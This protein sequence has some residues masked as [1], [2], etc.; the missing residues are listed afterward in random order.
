MLSRTSEVRSDSAAWVAICRSQAVIEFDTG[1]HILWA[2][3]IFL[4]LMGYC[5]AN[6]T[7]QH[8]RIFCAPELAETP[9]YQDFWRKLGAGEYCSGEFTRQTRTGA[10]VYL[11]ATYNPILGD[12]GRPLRILKIASDVTEH[13]RRSA[14]F[15][16]ISTA[17]VRSQAVIE[18]ALDGT[19]LTAND[20]FLAV[21]GYRLDEIVGQHHRLF[22]DPDQARS[23]QYVAFWEKLG[24]G[25][26]DSGVYRRKSRDGSDI[27]LQATYNPILD[28]DGRPVKVVKFATNITEN[29]EITAEFESRMNAI[30]VSQAVIEFDLDGHILDA[31]TNFLTA[32]GYSRNELVGQHHRILCDG[33]YAA[34]A[35]YGAFWKRLGRGEFDTGRYR[36][37]AR[38][39][40]A[41]WIQATYNPILDPE[42]RPRK[43]VKIASDITREVALEHEAQSRLED[44]EQFQAELR[45]GRDE[46]VVTMEELGYIV[47]SIAGIASQTKLL[48]LNATIEAA[49]AGEAGRG[50]SV[51]AA[52]VKK[53]ASQTREATERATIM[54]K[55][56]AHL[57]LVA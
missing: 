54:M 30:D 35:E 55:H 41:I 49:R 32:F 20:H 33:G 29:K 50:F 11:Q 47:A 6:L 38:D 36:R 39:G 44:A 18:F 56:R 46:L 22:C 43:V 23:P 28:P 4:D 57:S 25:A 21:T 10:V 45:R 53:L 42:G 52:E 40:H 17:M 2:N 1:G 48:A 16:A 8:H 34:S 15:Q 24:R 19:I 31:N 13:R 12:D 5:L 37:K 14:E 7:G 26:Y 51:V 9:A 27:W 3:D